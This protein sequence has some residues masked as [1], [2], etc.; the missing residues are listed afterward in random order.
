VRTASNS[1]ALL[2]ALTA[3]A[4]GQVF[5][6]SG[7]ITPP[8]KS[9]VTL[10]GAISPFQVSTL[11]DDAGRFQFKKLL[12][13]AYTISVFQ[14][15]R[16]E[17]R[18]TIE[19]GPAMADPHGK[20]RLDL[21]LTEADWVYGDPTRRRNAVS[22]SELT[23]PDRAQD[24]YDEARKALQRH[25]STAAL[26]HLERAVKLA[27]QYADAWNELGTIAYQTQQ[28]ARAEEC[29]R[30]SLWLDPTAFEPLV[31]LGGVLITLHRVDEAWQYN[32]Y[33]VLARP[34]DALANSQ[35]GLTYFEMGSFDLAIRH[36]E[37][38]RRI[39]PAH[40]SHPQLVLAEIHLRRGENAKAAEA[41]EDFLKYHPDWPQAE[42]MREKIEELR[43]V[44]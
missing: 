36:L 3:V 26:Q 25:D 4:A 16:G 21:R 34:D 18:K 30:E 8:G 13:G 33:A 40:F 9:A 6:L 28:F 22:A 20:V 32:G 35:M 12:P 14:P 1:A 39:D 2:F 24:E 10:F 42:K 29:F 17:A 7:Q 37:K 11:S 5:E 15:L 43:R 31:N 41:M 19:V 27:P 23:I 38:A 44:N